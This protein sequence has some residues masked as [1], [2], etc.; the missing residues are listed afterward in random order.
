M[1][2]Q[3]NYY[4]ISNS[5]I[6]NSWVLH[7]WCTGVYFAIYFKYY[8]LS[9]MQRKDITCYCRRCLLLVCYNIAW[10]IIIT[11]IMHTTATCTLTIFFLKIILETLNIPLIVIT[12]LCLNGRGKDVLLN[13]NYWAIGKTNHMPNV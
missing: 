8:I 12:I 1:K 3:H 6:N 10:T 5:K 11:I 4:N 9:V 13:V 2:Y 7:K